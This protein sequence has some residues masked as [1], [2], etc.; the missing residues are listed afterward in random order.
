MKTVASVIQ[1]EF[2]G[3]NVKVVKSTNTHNVGIS[4]PVVNETRNAIVIRHRNEYKTITKV[5][6]FFQFTLP[7]GT[8]VEIEGKVLVGRPEDRV[9]KSP[10]RQW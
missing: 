7:D 3:L 4:G 2:I 8:I 5:T 6:S 10:K 9:K 1:G